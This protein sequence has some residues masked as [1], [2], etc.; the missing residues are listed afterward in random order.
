MCV[1]SSSPVQPQSTEDLRTWLR[2]ASPAS[3]SQSQENAQEPTTNAICGPPPSTAS[4]QYDHDSRSWRTSQV[5]LFQDTLAEYSETWPRAGTIVDGGFY[6]RPKWE[7]PI[8]DSDCGLWPTPNAN[9]EIADRYT[10]ETS[11][12][13]FQQGRQIHL[14]QADKMW[15]TPTSSDAPTT[16]ADVQR[17]Q[18]LAA[19]VNRQ[20]FPTPRQFMHKDS[21]TDRGKGTLGEVV[22]GKLN[23]TWVEWLMGWPLGWTDLKPLE[24]DKFQRWWQQFGDF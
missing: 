6:L 11:R 13:H 3:H 17:F 1:S 4:V 12:K 19:E 14:S 21:E 23:P 20:K 22:G 9:E 16:G 7:R 24:M 8:A 5:C 15:P 10:L 2:Q 18:S